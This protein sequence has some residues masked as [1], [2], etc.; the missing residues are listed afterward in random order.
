VIYPAIPAFED[1]DLVAAQAELERHRQAYWPAP[2]NNHSS[3]RHT[4]PPNV[5]SSLLPDAT[6]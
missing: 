1:D 3:V 5:N 2:D 6:G 4:V